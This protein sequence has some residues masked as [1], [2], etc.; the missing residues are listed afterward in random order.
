MEDWWV[1][2]YSAD[3]H[4][5]VGKDVAKY[6]FTSKSNTKNSDESH[7]L[8]LS[9]LLNLQVIASFTFDA[10]CFSLFSIHIPLN[11]EKKEPTTP[12]F[13]DTAYISNEL[14]TILGQVYTQLVQVVLSLEHEQVP[15]SNLPSVF[16]LEWQNCC[17]RWHSR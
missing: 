12:I 10:E 1:L 14:K 15:R 2:A 4:L 11:S 6:Q 13:P 5:A 3:I 16:L 7:C 8:F 17:N 9:K